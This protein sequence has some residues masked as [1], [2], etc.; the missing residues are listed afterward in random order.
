M[1]VYIYIGLISLLGFT[2]YTQS[3]STRTG[4][5]VSGEV[6]IEKDKKIILPQ[7]DKIF[8]KSEPKSFK[9]DPL[10]VQFNVQE[11]GFDW[12]DYKSDVPYKF[13]AEPYPIEEYQNY[14]KLG[15]GNYASPLFEAGLFKSF[16]SFATS[17]KLFYESFNSGPVNDENSGNKRGG[18][19]FSGRYTTGSFII[20]PSISFQNRQYNFYGNADRQNSGFNSDVDEVQLDQFEVGLSLSGQG[21]DFS[22]EI[23]P[24]FSLANQRITSGNALNKE[25]TFATAG[26][27]SYKI[28]DAFTTGLDFESN[29]ASYDGGLSYSR[30]LINLNPWVTHRRESLSITAGFI[31]SSGKVYD[32]SKTGF[33]PNIR[34]EYDLSEEWTVFGLFSGGLS[35]NGLDQLLNQ[36]EF[37]DDSLAITH[38]EYTSKFGGGIKGAPIKNMLIEASVTNSS[39]KGLPFFTPS[40]SD[41]SRYVLSY[42]SKAVNVLTVES[43]ISFM[44]TATSTYGA[45][46]QINGYSVESLDRPWHKPSFVFEAYTSHNIQEK[47][48]VSAH[49]TSIGGIRA[50]ANVDFGYVK[51]PAFTDIGIGAKYLITKRASAFIDVN[52]LLNNEYERYLGYPIRGLAFKIGGQYRF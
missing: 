2:A 28:D 13:I 26:N 52:N 5:V 15:Y 20:K 38:S 25:S 40:I 23:K 50:P 30:S 46:L 36:N 39:I 29:V 45:K 22:Y 16:G 41:S 42:D 10:D 18:V 19:D 35:W 34:A 14:V 33:Y 17:T 49:V 31:V 8:L 6:V 21:A 12:P 48:I 47:I 43:S 27:F 32:S 4:E 1:R 51:L 7:A 9:N 11:P 37:L 44:P 3:D 24:S